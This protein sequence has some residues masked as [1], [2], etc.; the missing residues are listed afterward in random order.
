ME[1]G[2]V[3]AIEGVVGDPTGIHSGSWPFADASI[4]NDIESTVNNLRTFML[5][6]FLIPN[7]VDVAIQ[8]VKGAYKNN[9]IYLILRLQDRK[10][11]CISLGV[12][13]WK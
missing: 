4:I 6:V 10:N 5:R 2:P 3:P 8:V 11:G 9:A 13:L 12:K 1:A 7:E